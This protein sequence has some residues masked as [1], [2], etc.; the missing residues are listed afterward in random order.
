MKKL[1]QK[2]TKQAKAAEDYCFGDTVVVDNKLIVHD[3]IGSI[4]HGA[5]LA[6]IGILTKQE[7]VSLTVSLLNVIKKAKSGKFRV[8]S[9]DEDV[10]TKIEWYLTDQIGG[11]G[12]KIH[13][14]RSR[15][16]QVLVDL[17]LFTKEQLFAL[18]DANSALI[19][20]LYQFARLHEFVPMPGYTHMQKA[21]PS[22]V[23]MWAGSFSESLL[24]D[25]ELLKSSFVLNDQ[26]PLGSGAAYGVS[27]PIDRQKTSE[28]LGFSKVQ[29][30]SLYSQ[31]SRGKS[32]AAVMHACSQIMLTLARFAADVLLFTTAEYNFFRVDESLCTGS[33]IMPQKKN[34]DVMEMVRARA[35]AVCGYEAIVQSIISGLP[36]GYNADVGETKQPFIQA[37]ET[38]RQTVN[39]CCLVVESLHPNSDVLHAG[40]SPELYATHAA[41]QLVK[42]GMP[43]RDAYIQVGRNLASLH[44]MDPVA[45]LRATDHIGGPGN[46]NLQCIPENLAVKKT[47]WNKKRSVYIA[48]M[49]NLGVMYE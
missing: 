11:I 32:H 47:W 43:F 10:H 46:L 12:K 6:D 7:F 19:Q 16:D 40:C 18:F 33:S 49:K 21:M 20:T 30:N 35:Q 17:R 27:L 15:N 34:L 13:T 4:A 28:L 45:V 44:A 39:M 31:V 38:T 23:G 2:T 1:W 36:S 41:Y 9:G 48:A 37:I 14:G 3:A 25:I 29:N 8:E 26:C 42:N 5:M 24:D 22:S